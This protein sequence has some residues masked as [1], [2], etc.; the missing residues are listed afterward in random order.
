MVS[1]SVNVFN[2]RTILL[3]SSWLHNLSWQVNTNNNRRSM[4][5]SGSRRCGGGG[6]HS[7]WWMW[8]IIDVK[9][10]WT[11]RCISFA[12]KSQVAVTERARTLWLNHRND[13][14]P[15][16]IC[17]TVQSAHSGQRDPPALPKNLLPT[18]IQDPNWALSLFYPH[19]RLP[20]SLIYTWHLRL[21]ATEQVHRPDD[22]S[23]STNH[24]KAQRSVRA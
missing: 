6:H 5:D 20:G 19:A 17:S 2:P 12:F 24:I 18:T 11:L 22:Q 15:G 14:S 9:S 16:R 21:R 8:H 4:M 13:P 7:S 23:K 3:L 1:G 10:K